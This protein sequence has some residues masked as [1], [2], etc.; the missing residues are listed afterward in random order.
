[1]ATLQMVGSYPYQYSEGVDVQAWDAQTSAFLC[2]K[3]WSRP[4][5]KLTFL[6]A[7]GILKMS[8]CSIFLNR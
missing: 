7:Y 3:K 2:G 4:F 8:T 6:K 5:E 1:M